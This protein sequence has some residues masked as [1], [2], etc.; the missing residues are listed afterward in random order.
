MGMA[1]LLGHLLRIA[2]RRLL[3]RLP[4][5]IITALGRRLLLWC[6]ITL[7]GLLR[8]RGSS[9]TGRRNKPPAGTGGMRVLGVPAVLFLTFHTVPPGSNIFLL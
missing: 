6:V 5:C 8:L 1:A 9:G 4:G 7:R 3:L 2:L